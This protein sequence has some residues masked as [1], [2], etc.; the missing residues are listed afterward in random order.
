[1]P[2]APRRAVYFPKVKEAREI[3]KE[4]A[5]EILEMQLRIV[6]ESLAGGD[7]E[8]A[9]K[10]NQF[11]LEHMPE[12]EGVKVLDISVDKPKQVEG[13]TGPQISIGFA[14]G[15]IPQSQPALPAADVKVIDATI[16]EP[17]E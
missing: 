3:L 13:K 5:Q 6:T 9:M 10:A 12:D 4:K 14:L 2:N 16:N 15:G 8:T 11:L 17:D 1:M 7:F